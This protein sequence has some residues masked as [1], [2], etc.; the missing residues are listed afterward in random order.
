[1]RARAVAVRAVVQQ[2]VY[3]C[4]RSSTWVVESQD[5]VLEVGAARRHHHLGTD[6]FTQLDADLTC[7]QCQLTCR[8]NYQRYRHT[9]THSPRPIQPPTL[10]GT[11]DEYQY[12]PKCGDLLWLWNRAGWSVPLVD[13]GVSDQCLST[14]TT[15]T[16]MTT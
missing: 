7:L 9:H 10:S 14:T 8:H 12:Q 11:G 1:L 2:A 16:T 6:V 5:V 13:K 3:Q 4:G 15:T